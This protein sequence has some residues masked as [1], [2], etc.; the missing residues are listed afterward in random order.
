MT[1]RTPAIAV[2][3]ALEDEAAGLLA[4]V[5][6]AR[7]LL[8]DGSPA[9]EARFGGQS[10]VLVRSG[11]GRLRA[12]AAASYLLGHYP[13]SALLG[14]GFAGA[15][16]EGLRVGDLVLCEK[17]YAQQE[18]EAHSSDAALL[19][20]AAA[21]LEGGGRPFHRGDALTVPQ[22][23]GEP[24]AKAAL[25]RRMPVAVVEM[26]GYW[27]AEAAARRGVPFLALRVV[28]DEV[29]D[30]LPDENFLDETGVVQR[31]KA[32]AY[33]MRHPERTAAL[34]RLGAAVHKAGQSLAASVAAILEQWGS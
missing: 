3:A 8:M 5:E 19:Q 20:R 12:E 29:G 25:G 18:G 15:V 33:L 30:W 24:E 14:I 13:L 10:L 23:L 32:M 6:V 22:V 27:L 28:L 17:V 9:W 26:E 16:Q 4:K 31:H 2:V 1:S 11:P 34:M 21:T 7:R